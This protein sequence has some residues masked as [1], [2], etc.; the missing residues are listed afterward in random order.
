MSFLA[1][2]WNTFLYIPLFNAL[3]WLYNGYAN[4]NLGYAVI[5]LTIVLRFLLLPLSFVSA[6]SHTRYQFVE[7]KFAEL[8]KSYKEDT[9]K[10]K[11][12]ARK[13]MK[14]YKVSPWAKG[15]LL[16]I[17]GLVLVLLYQVFIHGITYSKLNVLYPGIA[18][19][20]LINTDFYGFDIGQHSVLWPAI[21]GLVLF[22]E[23]YIDQR[24]HKEGLT[25]N[26]YLYAILF[27]LMS[28]FL[29]W[30]LP[31][32]KSLFILTSLAFSYILGIIGFGGKS[33]DI[34]AK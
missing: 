11:E 22:L 19:P 4:E 18:R 32:V 34:K 12:E 17:Q 28:V 2:F 27:P 9:V 16:F 29:L 13:L 23:I 31:M 7:K 26:D 14:K 24:R 1:Y 10:L 21:V 25:T 6:R 5:Y 3:I 8:K 33:Q 20:E 15:L 30:L